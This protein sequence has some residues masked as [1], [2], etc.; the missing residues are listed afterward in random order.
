[1]P[2]LWQ[3]GGLAPEGGAATR[4]S[5]AVTRPGRWR[6][7]LVT[8]GFALAAAGC[9]SQV[10]SRPGTRHALLGGGGASRPRADLTALV[11][12][13]ESAPAAALEWEKKHPDAEN[14]VIEY[15]DDLWGESVGAEHE[16]KEKVLE[17]EQQTKTTAVAV[18]QPTTQPATTPPLT[19]TPAPALLPGCETQASPPVRCDGLQEVHTSDGTIS[20]GGGHD[21]RWYIYSPGAS[22]L[23]IN[24]AVSV[25]GPDAQLLIYEGAETQV[26][27][28]EDV[29]NAAVRAPGRKSVRDAL[30][31]RVPATFCV[32]AL[33]ACSHCLVCVSI[34]CA[35]VTRD[36]VRAALFQGG[37]RHELISV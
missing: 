35:G 33:A 25:H 3:A 21:C 19:T 20:A 27:M 28:H 12:I 2:C 9:V 23:H 18:L 15:M 17:A 36:V 13:D 16:R 22:K 34:A 31:P 6:I 24:L 14:T 7:A 26:Y 32:L 8:A 37:T 4:R 5:D 30:S 10:R 1:V 29:L 11:G